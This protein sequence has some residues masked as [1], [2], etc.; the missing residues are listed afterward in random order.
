MS[1]RGESAWESLQLL[2]FPSMGGQHIDMK[3]DQSRTALACLRQ[4]TKS[5]SEYHLMLLLECLLLL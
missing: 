2:G 3:S 5:H 1:Q 4:W